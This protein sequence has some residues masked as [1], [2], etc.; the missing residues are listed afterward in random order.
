MTAF[1]DSAGVFQVSYPSSLGAATVYTS[2][3][4]EDD[5]RT[6]G[7]H[8]GLVPTDS[9]LRQFAHFHRQKPV[10]LEL[11]TKA[12]QGESDDEQWRE[13]SEK[14]AAAEDKASE[15]WIGSTQLASQTRGQNFGEQKLYR[16]SHVGFLWW[17]WVAVSYLECREGVF[18]KGFGLIWGSHWDAM[19]SAYRRTFAELKWSPSAARAVLGVP[20]LVY[21]VVLPSSLEDAATM[22]AL[23]RVRDSLSLP[24]V[25]VTLAAQKERASE[26]A[27]SLVVIGTSVPPR[28]FTPVLRLLNRELPISYVR[29]G[30]SKKLDA[31]LLKTGIDLESFVYLGSAS[32]LRETGNPPL[33]ENQVNRLLGDWSSRK[34]FSDWV[35]RVTS[36]K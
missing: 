11:W 34:E 10:T 15:T 33:S 14:M 25:K 32:H 21:E 7:I 18:L 27:W 2:E 8:F 28:V 31:E 13:F 20:P 35:A 19:K 16:E 24:N 23:G 30:W 26:T 1:H 6:Y 22:A 17:H 5:S 12:T 9:L 36:A 3:S 4:A 29:V